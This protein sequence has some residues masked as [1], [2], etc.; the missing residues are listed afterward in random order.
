[1]FKAVRALNAKQYQ[2]PT[3]LYMRKRKKLLPAQ[4]N[5]KI[6]TE[7]YKETFKKDDVENITPFKGNPNLS[8]ERYLK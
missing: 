1:M 5:L 4:I 2:N 8:T 7:F 6:T 3:V